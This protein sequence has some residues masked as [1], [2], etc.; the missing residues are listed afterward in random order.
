MAECPINGCTVM[1][2]PEILMCLP[3][4]RMVPRELGRT[5]ND[6]WRRVRRD[7]NAYREAR[8]EAIAIVNAKVGERTGSLFDA[9]D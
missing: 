3:H 4:W 7:P 6:T 8:E 5:V 2:K 1:C 9:D